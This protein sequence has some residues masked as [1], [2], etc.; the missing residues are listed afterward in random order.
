MENTD[1]M[2]QQRKKKIVKFNLTNRDSI[3]TV[4]IEP[5]GIQTVIL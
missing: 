2:F 3:D 5:T 4:Q 1:K